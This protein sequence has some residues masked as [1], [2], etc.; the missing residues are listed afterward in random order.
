[1]LRT[2]YHACPG[3]GVEWGLRIA[4]PKRA[5]EGPGLHS[6]SVVH[7][8][9]FFVHIT[10]AYYTSGNFLSL[11]LQGA[12]LSP[13]STLSIVHACLWIHTVQALANYKCGTDNCAVFAI[14]LNQ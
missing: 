6:A 3:I 8:W 14:P 7:V 1:M 2:N 11:T 13:T 10:R 5:N 4:G 12:P 9:L